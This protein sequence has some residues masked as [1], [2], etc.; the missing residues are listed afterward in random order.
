[1]WVKTSQ[2]FT[3]TVVVFLTGEKTGT[4]TGKMLNTQGLWRELIVDGFAPDASEAAIYLNVYDSTGTVW[5]DDAELVQR[6]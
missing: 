5:F 2:E 6:D 3:G 1:M 4:R